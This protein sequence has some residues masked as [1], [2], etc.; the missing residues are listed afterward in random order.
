MLGFVVLDERLGIAELL[1]AA[2]VVAGVVAI[3][4]GER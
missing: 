2:I 3:T 4:A 1:G